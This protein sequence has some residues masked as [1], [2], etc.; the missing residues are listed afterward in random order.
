[1][2]GAS[3]VAS[4]GCLATGQGARGRTIFDF[5]R[6]TA[7]RCASELLA[8]AR[9]LGARGG[10]LNLPRRERIRIFVRCTLAP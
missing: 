8:G 10:R 1:M 5:A 4:I 7:C 6:P 9:W 2:S 3:S